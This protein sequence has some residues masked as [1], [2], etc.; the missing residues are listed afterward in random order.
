MKTQVLL[1]EDEESLLRLLQF[2]LEM[3][4][5]DVTARSRGSQAIEEGLKK[6]YSLIILDVMIPE[7][8]GFEVCENL[9]KQDVKTPILFLTAKGTDEDKIKGL[10]IGG[11][12]Y[13]VKPFNLEELLLR[14]GNLVKRGSEMIHSNNELIM[15]GNSSINLKQYEFADS[16]GD[17]RSLTEK[18]VKLLKLLVQNEG[19]VVSRDEI[20]NKVWG[21]EKYPTTRTIDNFILAFRKYFEEDPKKPKYFHSIRGVGYKYTSNS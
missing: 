17:T 16:K 20:L 14:V 8:S 3:E 1:I 9:R 12:D 15:I 5:Y 10:K 13:L 18:E 2:N 11:D 6:G 19:V 4:G 7:M 21:Y